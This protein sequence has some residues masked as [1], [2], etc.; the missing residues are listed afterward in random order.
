[1]F[2]TILNSFVSKIHYFN[3]Y[4]KKYPNLEI[5]SLKLQHTYDCQ[6]SLHLIQLVC[7][8]NLAISALHIVKLNAD[9]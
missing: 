5:Y 6:F 8:Q 7:V 1:M 9:K 4:I 2:F 3:C